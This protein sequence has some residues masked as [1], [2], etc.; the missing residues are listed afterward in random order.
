MSH[1]LSA[2]VSVCVWATDHRRESQKALLLMLL[3]AFLF[4]VRSSSPL[5]SF[6]THPSASE[7][8]D[9]VSLHN[10][11]QGQAC[12]FRV[13]SLHSVDIP[14]YMFARVKPH[15]QIRFSQNDAFSSPCFILMCCIVVFKEMNLIYLF[16]CSLVPE[17][18]SGGGSQQYKAGEG[19]YEKTELGIRLSSDSKKKKKERKISLSHRCLY[20][21]VSVFLHFRGRDRPQARAVSAFQSC[22]PVQNCSGLSAKHH[23]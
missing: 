1:C 10:R 16:H 9:K 5:I 13:F 15:N 12:S 14:R 11:S 23:S 3:Q 18:V 20:I 22:V 2:C 8:S 21:L 17:T 4:S 19:R 6:W 7:A